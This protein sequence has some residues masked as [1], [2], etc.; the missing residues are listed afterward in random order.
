MVLC[1]RRMGHSRLSILR[2]PYRRFPPTSAGRELSWG[3]TTTRVTSAT[4]SFWMGDNTQSI[5]PQARPALLSVVST[6]RV[7]CQEFPVLW[8]RALPVLPTVL[9]CPR[10]AASQVSI[11]PVQS[12]A[13]PAL[14]VRLVQ[15]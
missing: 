4:V 11:H 3:D 8:R 6:P 2:A 15:S 14:L 9:S 13:L 10:K 1:C 7:K 12:A 5:T